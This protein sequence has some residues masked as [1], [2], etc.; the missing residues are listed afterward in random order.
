MNEALTLGEIRAIHP[1]PWKTEHA[2]PPGALGGFV[3][4]I[5]AAGKEVGLFHM[6]R[7]AEIATAH[8]DAMTQP[9][10]ATA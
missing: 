10:K 8:L 4:M 5:D 3:R 2:I 9:P 1:F 6:T 7:L